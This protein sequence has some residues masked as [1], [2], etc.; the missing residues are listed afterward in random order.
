MDSLK[1]GTVHF[2]ALQDQMGTS[3]QAVLS[4]LLKDLAWPSVLQSFGSLQYT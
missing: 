3:K 1:W 2:S 4:P